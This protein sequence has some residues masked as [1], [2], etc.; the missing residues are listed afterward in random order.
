MTLPCQLTKCM[1]QLLPT[2]H[3]IHSSSQ[4]TN[5]KN[6]DFATLCTKMS[7]G[8]FVNQSFQK[9][10]PRNEFCGA[11]NNVSGL[12]FGQPSQRRYLSEG[13]A[14]DEKYDG[15][16]GLFSSSACTGGGC[17]GNGLQLFKQGS[18]NWTQK[19]LGGTDVTITAQELQTSDVSGVR[20]SK[21]RQ[22]KQIP[23]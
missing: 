12:G 21:H 6:T 17:S 13:D 19:L 7:K 1:C 22:G 23:T 8:G 9:G 10:L 11:N 3:K 14:A 2:P 20:E 4:P 16:L 18:G 15:Y 5:E